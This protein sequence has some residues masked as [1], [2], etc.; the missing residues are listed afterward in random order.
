MDL[1]ELHVSVVVESTD[2]VLVK[3]A[4]AGSEAAAQALFERHWPA[5]WKLAYAMTGSH[6][7]ADDLAQ[8]AMVRA[9][10]SLGRIEGRAPFA[11]WVRR[12][13]VNATIDD[14][15]KRKREVLREPPETVAVQ[16]LPA[17]PDDAVTA[18]VL[19]LP[20][21]RRIIVVLHY[22]FDYTAE[23]IARLLGI[24]A[25]TVG[26]RLGRA[27]TELRSRLEVRD[28]VD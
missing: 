6:T 25:G 9:F 17:D 10:R 20:P 26:S 14:L 8:E 5:V 4:R 28:H 22:W 11:A 2:E 15:R 13:V 21:P 27:L 7:R 19:A 18:A 16:A 23:E 12:V 1:L 24:P 3:Q